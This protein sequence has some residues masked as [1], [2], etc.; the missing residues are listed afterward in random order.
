MRISLRS[1]DV[2]RS[3]DVLQVLS[4]SGFLLN[5]VSVGSACSSLLS[6]VEHSNGSCLSKL[7][8]FNV[9]GDDI[10]DLILDDDFSPTLGEFRLDFLPIAGETMFE[11]EPIFELRSMFDLH[12]EA[13]EETFELA[14][15]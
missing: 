12:P 13:G 4:E 1:V 3:T 14:C 15:V 2:H 10:T 7:V 6:K 11:L 9:L 8:S 5:G